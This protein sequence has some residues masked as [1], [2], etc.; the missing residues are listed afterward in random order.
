M[1]LFCKLVLITLWLNI[2]CA[3]VI[4]LNNKLIERIDEDKH[5]DYG[6]P[7]LEVKYSHLDPIKNLSE[8]F[9]KKIKKLADDQKAVFNKANDKI[10]QYKDNRDYDLRSYRDSIINL[11][12]TMRNNM[13]DLE[14]QR[15]NIEE[16]I[17]IIKDENNDE[18]VD[19]KNIMRME[20]EKYRDKLDKLKERKNLLTTLTNLHCDHCD[21]SLR[22]FEVDV[23]L[24]HVNKEIT[25][26]EQNFLKQA[27]KDE[28]KLRELDLKKS[29]EL[30][31]RFSKLVDVLKNELYQYKKNDE[32][33]KQSE[34]IINEWKEYSENIENLQNNI[35]SEIENLTNNS[36]DFIIL[37]N[38][39]TEILLQ[40]DFKWMQNDVI[41]LSLIDNAVLGGY[42]IDNVP[43]YII[44]SK[45][46][47]EYIYGKYAYGKYRKHAY[48]TDNVR[49]YGVIEF[50]VSLIG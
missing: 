38:T 7:I 5:D 24:A 28:K 16:D 43:L 13:K 3:N 39:D 23:K 33:N 19:A 2:S 48:V 34:N 12:E 8:K 36:L 44:R 25:E 1:N 45:S 15:S 40:N 18:D 17:A 30:N 10:K 26:L 42:D 37:S 11:N 46:G 9:D 49:E 14:K 22:E 27:E 47:D 29:A 31:V 21:E 4:N 50:E 32:I 35:R 20:E 6:N 41:L